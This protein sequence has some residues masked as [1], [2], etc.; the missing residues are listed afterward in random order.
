MALSREQERKLVHGKFYLALFQQQA[1]MHPRWEPVEA[2]RKDEQ[3]Y[4]RMTGVP[5][6]LYT[7]DVL[8]IVEEPIPL[9][10]T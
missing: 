8:N 2:Y 4:F 3:I 9:P 6:K 5:Q 1:F 10:T 7:G